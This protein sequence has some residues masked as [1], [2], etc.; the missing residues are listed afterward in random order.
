MPHLES[1]PAAHFLQQLDR[2]LPPAPETEIRTH[3]HHLRAERSDEDVLH[4]NLRRLLAEGAIEREHDGDV[5]AELLEQFE[6]LP[7]AHERGGA[8][9][10]REDAQRIAVEREHGRHERIAAG[11]GQKRVDHPVMAEV[12]AVELANRDR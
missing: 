1:I 3:V 8:R 10:G 2:A 9:I 4:E 7:V 5:N 11:L 6:L 12:D